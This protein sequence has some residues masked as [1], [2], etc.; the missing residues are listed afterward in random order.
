MR[1]TTRLAGAV[2]GLA[3]GAVAT[4][5][6]AVAA[7][8]EG[9]QPAACAQEQKQLD[10]AEDAYER[11][12]KVF[13]AQQARVKK[14]HDRVEKAKSAQ[15][16]ARAERALAE[17]RH[18]RDDAAKDKRAQKQRVAKA[19]ARLDACQKEQAPVAG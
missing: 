17:A 10:R 18:D 2:A 6:S 5:P 11:V 3:L 7:E 9:Q 4:V 12:S 19:Q 1:T 8:P 13:A 15:E 16:K 14:A